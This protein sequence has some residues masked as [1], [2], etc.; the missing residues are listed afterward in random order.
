[1]NYPTWIV[2]LPPVLV[3]IFTAITK[4]IN[5]AFLISIIAAAFLASNGTLYQAF[6]IIKN[7]TTSQL[8]DIDNIYQYA[9]LIMVG[10]L[11]AIL[12]KSGGA[13]A[14]AHSFTR[15]IKSAKT[16]ETTTLLISA[17]LSI[18]D[19]LGNSIAGYIM[20]PITDKFHIARAKLA[21]LVHSIATPLIMILPI[22][23][24]I[25]FIMSSLNEAGIASSY[26]DHLSIK[27]ISDPYFVFL[28]TIPFTF[29]SIL[30]LFSALFIVNYKISYGPMRTME[31]I[32]QTTGNL[33]GNTKHPPSSQPEHTIQKKPSM[34]DFIIPL[35]TLIGT[36]IIINLYTGNYYLLGGTESFINAFKNS[37]S[38]LS[39]FLA[40]T[41]SLATSLVFALSRNKLSVHMVPLLCKEGALGMLNPLIMVLLSK[42]FSAILRNNLHTGTYLATILSGALP[43]YLIAPMFYVI[44][45]LA[46]ILM[47]TS[48]GTI[49]L[50]MPV[51]SPIVTTY[52]LVTLPTVAQHVPLLY[53]VLG[54]IFSGAICG[55]QLSPI[56]QTTL[57]A[58]SSVGIDPMTH[59]KTQIP[60]AIPAIISSFFAFLI[61]GLCIY[62]KLST[63]W[64][65]ILSL[66]AGLI[67]CC[68]LIIFI[69]IITKKIKKSTA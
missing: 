65:A 46:A 20:R 37:N 57:M 13:H 43:I 6:E 54:A 19:F 5:R 3:L 16:A 68:T 9:F 22:S 21:Y 59:A 11:I 58:S 8:S 15:H 32:A 10:I 23:T 40:G 63:F 33:F 60:Y 25:A 55:D 31:N 64:N 67:A 61:S 27:I 49:A 50:L 56:S 66:G 62:Y 4:R 48:W 1:M 26:Q 52:T 24:W 45:L 29:Y 35:V 7:N 47:G 18:D 34:L 42:I 39:M 12:D 51:A 2:L 14:F 53:P 36:F 44:A 17:S 30:I 38:G 41:A 28:S 69:S